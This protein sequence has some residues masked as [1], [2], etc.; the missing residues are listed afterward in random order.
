[1]PR[2][3]SPSGLFERGSGACGRLGELRPEVLDRLDQTFFK[4]H[5][6]FPPEQGARARVGDSYTEADRTEATTVKT[7]AV[8]G[9]AR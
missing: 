3:K 9:T 8:T 7:T 6:R 4:S 5:L 2:R 1:M